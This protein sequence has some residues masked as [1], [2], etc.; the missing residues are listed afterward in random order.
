[1]SSQGTSTAADRPSRRQR[2]YQWSRETQLGRRLRHQV[3]TDIEVILDQWFGYHLVVIGDDM[4]VPVDE[5]S[6]VRHVTR[7]IPRDEAWDRGDDGGQQTAPKV[8]AQ[9]ERVAVVARD[10]ELPLATESVDVVVMFNA[11]QQNEEPHRLLREVHRVLTQDG[12]LLVVDANANSLWGWMTRLV[13]L[14]RL[15]RADRSVAISLSKLEDWLR[16]LNF[17]MAPARHKL[18]L[19]LAHK[20]GVGDFL[21][22]IDNWLAEHNIPLGSYYVLF[23]NKSVLG[24][25]QQQPQ[26]RL[27][28]RMM[29]LPVANPIIGGARGASSQRTL[30]FT[31]DK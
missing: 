17:H 24:Y 12:H 31:P 29:G 20:S 19:P 26:R 1:M 27:R 2:C 4:G 5:A 23:G 21:A 14:F 16:L 25:L 15:R 9:A 13:R 28:A 30:E 11:L 7:I 10:A 18:A 3:T 8:G 22:R 6:R